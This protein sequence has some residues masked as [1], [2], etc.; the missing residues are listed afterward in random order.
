MY[1]NTVKSLCNQA[2]SPWKHYLQQNLSI[3]I[4]RNWWI[5]HRAFLFACGFPK[6]WFKHLCTDRLLQMATAL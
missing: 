6:H 3:K 2:K 4:G 5:S 1:R